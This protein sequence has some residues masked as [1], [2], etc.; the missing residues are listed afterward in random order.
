[1]IILKSRVTGQH[2]HSV[3][4]ILFTHPDDG[5]LLARLICRM[6]DI[7]LT[8]IYGHSGQCQCPMSILWLGIFLRLIWVHIGVN[9]FCMPNVLTSTFFHFYLGANSPQLKV[10]VVD[11]LTSIMLV[12]LFC[13]SVVS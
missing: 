4:S 13:L 1:M 5:G 10:Y 11:V 3:E 9:C 2:G 6:C 8:Y 12:L 7:S